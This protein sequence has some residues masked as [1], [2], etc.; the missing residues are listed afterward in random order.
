MS[1]VDIWRI[2]AFLRLQGLVEQL[3]GN[4]SANDELIDNLIR[5][6]SNLP[7]R[8]TDKAAYVGLFGTADVAGGR[9]Q[10][11]ARLLALL[12]QLQNGS[13]GNGSTAVDG[14]VDDAI[15][16]LS[17]L[18]ARPAGRDPY[19]SLFPPAKMVWLTPLLVRSMTSTADPKQV[20]RLTPHLNRTMVEYN[21]NTPLRQAHFLAQI[22]H[23]SDRFN[24]LEEYASGAAYE[25]RDDLGNIYPGDGVRFKGRGLIQITG[26]TNYERCG[27]ALGVDLIK[28]PKRLSDPDLAC[29]SAG[30]FWETNRLNP[31]ADQDDVRTVTRII[32]GG[33]NGLQDRINLLVAAKKVLKID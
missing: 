13:T 5:S 23:E 1:Q 28:N 29:R 33:Y 32:N 10:A 2:Q 11:A 30:W 16:A 4:L 15:R 22:A 19:E 27:K 14:L 20:E 7:S 31:D 3:Q 21:I 26:R 24:A 18:P 25:G 8:P 17:K 12:N 6:L 9:K